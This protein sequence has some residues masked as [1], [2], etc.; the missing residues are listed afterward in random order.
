M[1]LQVTSCSA[2][3]PAGR[4]SRLAV[5]SLSPP[6]LRASSLLSVLTWL[7]ASSC[8]WSLKTRR[9]LR[10]ASRGSADSRTALKLLSGSSV[11]LLC[12]SC[13]TCSLSSL[14]CRCSP[15]KGKWYP[16]RVKNLSLGIGELSS[17]VPGAP[18]VL[19]SASRLNCT[20]CIC[21]TSSSGISCRGNCRCWISLSP[22]SRNPSNPNSLATREGHLSSR[23]VTAACRPCFR[24]HSDSRCA[25][26]LLKRR[27]M[28]LVAVIDA[29]C[30]P[31]QT[32][33][34]D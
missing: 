18:C 32:K 2:V 4:D 7:S 3:K 23:K 20:P 22:G 10:L 26:L 28:A 34:A 13:T 19:C 11:R 5:V 27:A 30:Q 21:K 16:S 9:V 6:I 25:D 24:T 14:V 17:G 29:A 12:L 33:L 8:R 1:F 31:L 15:S